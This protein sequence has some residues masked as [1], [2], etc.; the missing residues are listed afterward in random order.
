MT[1]EVICCGQ[2]VGANGFCDKCGS[3]RG[4]RPDEAASET[5][6]SWGGGDVYSLPSIAVGEPSL[7]TDPTY[8]EERQYCGTC[9]AP[10]GRRIGAQPAIVE[11]ACHRCG[12]RFSFLPKLRTGDVVAGRY[13]VLGWLAIGGLGWLYLAQDQFLADMRVVLK[14]VHNPTDQ[15]ALQLARKERDTLSRLDHPNIVRIIT[16]VEHPNPRT[17][18]PDEF[19]V[20]EHVPGLSL[21]A[22]LDEGRELH[23]EDVTA[24]GRYI[25][26]A[27]DH[28]HGQQLL[29]CDM[30]PDNVMHSGS[31][32]KVIDLG[33]TRAFGDRHSAKVGTRP[34]QVDDAE[35]ARHG[36]TVRSDVH[37]V[38]VTLKRLFE[39]ARERESDLDELA[40]AVRSMHLVLDRATAPYEER[41]ASAVEM[42]E[43]LDGVHRE[44]LSLRDH[45]PRRMPATRFAN[46]HHR[47]DVSLGMVPG[48]DRWTRTVK[49]DGAI[50]DGCPS[51]QVAAARLPA[52]RPSETDPVAEF[53][54]TRSTTEPRQLIREY[55]KAPAESVELHLARARAHLELGEPAE[56]QTGIDRAAAMLGEWSEHDWRIAWHDGLLW[57]AKNDVEAARLA[58]QDVYADVPGEVAPKLAIGFCLELQRKYTEAKQHYEVAWR[59][60]EQASAAFGL[61]RICLRAGDRAGAVDHLDK[62]PRVSRHYDAARVAAVRV[63]LAR[64]GD[65]RPEV[66]HIEA[67]S[68]RMPL[69][70]LDGGE[71][72]GET[73]QR[74]TTTLL[75]VALEHV[76]T[77]DG[78]LRGDALLGEVVT[79]R[80]LKE[81]LEKSFRVL[82]DHAADDRQRHVLIDVAN[83]SRPRTKR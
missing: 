51:P 57:L 83:E 78:A 6:S 55:A 64:L 16:Y 8:P 30:K 59:R 77:G 76:R 4:A 72:N 15:L 25:L 41:F 26:A 40:F 33:G 3:P 69:L 60:D 31:R 5:T 21:Q 48:L 44:I 2:P 62:V 43:Q 71:P 29:Y 46:T 54:A 24:Y 1:D 70:Y 20:M 68:E 11:G 28:L 49:P 82:A 14:G 53:L 19:I 66:R 73:R 63:L 17:G 32:I 74:L 61:A 75:E 12:T 37:T 45:K 65:Q 13:E 50:E 10:V 9:E 42:S 27:L 39:A 22:V 34:F 79:K 35:I 67:A 23:L 56:A 7:L 58:F 80:G 47:L 81:R 36:L 18:V 38:G 52:P